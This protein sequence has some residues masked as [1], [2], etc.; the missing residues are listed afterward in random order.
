MRKAIIVIEKYCDWLDA[1]S[2][3]K[4][5]SNYSIEL[6]FLEN[7]RNDFF[8]INSLFSQF[9]LKEIKI[10]GH[11]DKDYFINVLPYEIAKYKFQPNDIVAMPFVR[12]ISIWKAL[13]K[14]PNFV[15][16]IHISE[17][18]PENFGQIGYRLGFRSKKIK[19]WITLPFAKLFAILNKIDICYFPSYPFFNNPF[20]KVTRLVHIPPLVNSKKIV[21]EELLGPVK[22][23]L[24]IGG[25]GFDVAKMAKVL[26]LKYYI[27]TSKEMEI[28]IDGVS[29]PLK[30]RI[31]AEEI[32]IGN[33]VSALFS[34]TS[35]VVVWCKRINPEIP[36][37]CYKSSGINHFA[38]PLYSYF[39]KKAL[40]KMGIKV[41]DE[42][43]EMLA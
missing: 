25:F 41:L 5:Y 19:T 30:E 24:I 16:T 17:G 13:K 9:E 29:I 1:F 7:V 18:M 22:R 39:A 38:G 20:T 43:K 10:F 34:Y 37:Q 28:I 35:N 4:D 27:A 36:I 6:H 14:I 32:I 2:I 15:I 23:P 31:S 21:L 42:P 40:L 33:Y 12:Y 11:Q 8:S 26:E 3:V